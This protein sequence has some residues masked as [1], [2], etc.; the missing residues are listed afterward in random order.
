MRQRIVAEPC[1]FGRTHDAI[2]IG[3]ILVTTELIVHLLEFFGC[4]VNSFGH[5]IPLA[6][7]VVLRAL[8]GSWL[9]KRGQRT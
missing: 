4:G 3:V 5:V 8:R 9:I 7:Q 1:R 2:G 6:T